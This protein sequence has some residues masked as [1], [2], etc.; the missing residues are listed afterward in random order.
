MICHLAMSLVLGWSKLSSLPHSV[1]SIG[2]ARL[3]SRTFPY[4]WPRTYHPQQREHSSRNCFWPRDTPRQYDNDNPQRCRPPDP[5]VVVPFLTDFKIDALTD[6]SGHP[7]KAELR[8]GYDLSLR[9]NQTAVGIE[10]SD[11]PA[12]AT[13]IGKIA[14]SFNAVVAKSD[15]VEI[16]DLRPNHTTT[17]Q[18]PSGDTVSLTFKQMPDGFA[19]EILAE[20]KSADP[21]MAHAYNVANLRVLDASGKAFNSNG[22]SNSGNQGRVQRSN[23]YRIGQNTQNVSLG[24]PAK[25][26]FSMPVSLTSTPVSSSEFKNLAFAIKRH[27]HVRDPLR[28]PL[29]CDR[30]GSVCPLHQRLG[31]S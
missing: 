17:R 2:P 18:S 1:A 13:D 31:G 8:Q 30:S 15:S 3:E 12:E 21:K 6:Q 23:N 20:L 14:F 27:P 28:H 25:I 24:P 26:V 16:D 7:L 5:N 10:I 22:G 4:R 9:N 29:L 11:V 19:V